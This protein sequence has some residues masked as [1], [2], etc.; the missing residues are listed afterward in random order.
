MNL[1]ISEGV[2][3]QEESE[4]LKEMIDY[5][6]TIGHDSQNNHRYSYANLAEYDL[7]TD[8]K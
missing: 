3:T 6:N 7:L 1:L 4:Q 5:R 8:I 2:I